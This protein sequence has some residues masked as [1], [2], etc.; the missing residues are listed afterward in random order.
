MT[1][2]DR[3]AAYLRLHR[4]IW[5]NVADLNKRFN[6]T[7]NQCFKACRGYPDI[8]HKIIP[9]HGNNRSL[10]RAKPEEKE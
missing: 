3:V 6:M 4:G 9:N 2:G 10:Y 5:I 7:G 1:I 8:E